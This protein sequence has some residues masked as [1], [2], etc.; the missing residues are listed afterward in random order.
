MNYILVLEIMIY[1]WVHKEYVK[2]NMVVGFGKLIK[3]LIKYE[4][5]H[6]KLAFCAVS[7]HKQHP[8]N[9]TMQFWHQVSM[10]FWSSY[11]RYGTKG[12]KFGGGQNL[13]FTSGCFYNERECSSANWLDPHLP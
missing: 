5:L 12:T 9:K 4:L 1:D 11:D 2:L 7:C 6:Q 13:L 8:D 3:I 10:Q